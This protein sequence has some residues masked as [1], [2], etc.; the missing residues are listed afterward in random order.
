MRF[1]IDA[2]LSPTLA[3]GLREAGHDAVHVRDHDLQA[4]SDRVILAHARLEQRIL[5]SADTDFGTA[6]A[7]AGDAAPSVI[8][9]RKGAGRRT[10][11]QLGLIEA[12]LPDLEEPLATGCVVVIEPSR[13]RVRSLPISGASG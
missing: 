3:E 13:V 2:N 9:F 12:N 5:V 1:L 6:L 8:L 10:P 7:R 4:A 11:E